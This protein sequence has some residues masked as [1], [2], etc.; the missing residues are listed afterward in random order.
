MSLQ[1]SR[2]LLRVVIAQLCRQLGWNAIQ[3]SPLQLLTIILERYILQLGCQAHRFSELCMPAV[4][5]V[6]IVAI[7]VLVTVA[8]AVY[9]VVTAVDLLQDS[10][11]SF[12]YKK[13]LLILE[14]LDMAHSLG[15]NCMEQ[16]LVI[17]I[18]K[19]RHQSQVQRILSCIECFVQGEVK[20][21][22]VPL[23]SLD[24]VAVL[25]CSWTNG[26][27]SWRPRTSI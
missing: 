25:H 17:I 7:V 13:P 5:S 21:F 14:S 23:A 4:S 11:L 8:V 6:V 10:A 20:W 15:W 19:R 26:T 18:G 2:S 9:T 12:W 27:E 24:C 3:S 22:P 16:F 1:Y